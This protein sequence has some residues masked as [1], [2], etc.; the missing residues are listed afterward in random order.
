MGGTAIS[1]LDF[2]KRFAGT[3]R[4]SEGPSSGKLK[5]C[6]QDGEP[7]LPCKEQASAISMEGEILDLNP[8]SK[9]RE[10]TATVAASINVQKIV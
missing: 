7:L 2:L 1:I 10:D 4:P 8:I 3:H 6:L 9:L 5:H